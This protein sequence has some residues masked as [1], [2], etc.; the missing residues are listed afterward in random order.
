MTFRKKILVLAPYDFSHNIAG[1]QQR[2]FNLYYGLAKKFDVIVLSHVWIGKFEVRIPIENLT[3]VI[4]PASA[5]ALLAAKENMNW[6]E[7][8]SWDIKSH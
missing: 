4:L 3:E 2:C 5:Q 6:L 8:D 7:S 1:G